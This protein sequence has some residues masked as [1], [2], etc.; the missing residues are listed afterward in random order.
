MNKLKDFSKKFGLAVVSL[1]WPALALAQAPAQPGPATSA[2]KIPGAQ[3]GT[4]SGVL[5]LTC[6]IFGW[7]FYFLMALVVIFVVIAAF[8]YLTSAGEAEK[9]RNAQNTLLYAAIAA[10]VALLAWGVPHIVGDFFGV[11]PFATC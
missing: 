4:V 7:L 8:R 3:I 10:A 6:V 5:N 1:S 11:A 9:V 2:A